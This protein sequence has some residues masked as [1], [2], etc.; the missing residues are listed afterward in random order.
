[1]RA[2][3]RSGRVDAKVTIA[4]G[5]EHEDLSRTLRRFVEQRCP[6]EVTRQPFEEELPGL[7]VF[8]KELGEQGWL[9][10]H[11][12]E[13]HGGQ[14]YGVLETAVALEEFGYA[15]LPGPLLSTLVVSRLVS[16]HGGEELRREA[17]PGLLDG[18]AAAGLFLGDGSLAASEDDHGAVVLSGTLRP[19]LGA[20]GA[21]WLL[22]PAGGER[23]EATS[24]W[25]LEVA[26]DEAGPAEVETLPAMDPSRPLGAV[27]LRRAVVP[28][29]GRLTGLDTD[30]LRDLALV[31][32]AA[33]CVGGSRWC[34]E[35][36]ATYATERVQFGRP[37]GQFQAVKHR[38]ADMLVTAEASAAAAFDAAVAFDGTGDPNERSLAAAIAGTVCLEGF[39]ECAKACV[40]LHGGIG[41][42]WEHDAHRYL[43]RAMATKSLLVGRRSLPSVVAGAVLAGTR[44]SVHAELPEE[45]ESLRRALA[46]AVAQ[47]ASL[48]GPARRAFLV[49]EGLLAPHFPPPFGRGAGALEQVVIDEALAGARV[50]RPTLGVG[51][52][53][54]PTL[55]T[56]GTEEQKERFVRPTLLG[57]QS[58]CQLFS[59]PGAGSDLAALRTRAEPVEGGWRLTGQKVWTSL[60]QVADFGICLAR[61]HPEAPKHEGITYFIV[62]MKAEG[63]DIRPLRE[64]TGQAMFNEVFLDQ[65]FVPDSQVVGAPGH[66]WP[67]ART[68][69]ANERVSMSSGSTFGIG[70]EALVKQLAKVRGEVDPA[71]LEA[72][73]RLLAEAHGLAVMG[74]RSLL[75]SLSGADP[76]PTASVRKLLGAEH[77]QR[78]QQMGLHLLGDQAAVADGAGARW[79]AGFLATRC[80]TIAG[81]TSEVQRNVIAE[82]L[83]GQ[84]RDPEPVASGQPTGTGRGAR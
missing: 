35:T 22:V 67:I 65:V 27:T 41:F 1:V 71:D 26:D 54:L 38:L 39:I 20:P 31:L 4:V 32:G 60:A 45:A 29:S 47:A 34:L 25:L 66:G 10:L 77:E 63:L 69:L 44:R 6:A 72:V 50:Q 3:G 70:V 42:T 24:W 58:W 53:A 61:S 28:A 78:V 64:L 51:A 84:P 8:F 19:V 9:G 7:P 59:E 5:G 83:L 15:G 21:R 12:D 33:E 73:G 30:E 43:K 68:T 76:G 14:G 74:H 81:G 80:L 52:W 23:G 18:S 82:R 79:G 40:Q 48:E 62:D 75:R 56:H 46:P 17:L 13:A 11:V 57:E 16:R 55:I 36:T 49:E 2:G 37:I